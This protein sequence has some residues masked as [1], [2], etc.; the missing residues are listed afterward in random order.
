MFKGWQISDS[1]DAT[2]HF[3]LDGNPIDIKVDRTYRKDVYDAY[4]DHYVGFMD[5][6]TIGWQ[7]Q[8]DLTTLEKVNINLKLS[9]KRKNVFWPLKKLSLK[10][11][12]R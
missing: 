10:M 1:D 5:V 12:R 2:I 7:F 9:V 11:Y 3:Y 8:Y 4:F 6:N